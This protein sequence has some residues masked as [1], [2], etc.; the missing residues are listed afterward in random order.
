M[1]ARMVEV[2]AQCGV[3]AHS[4]R[5]YHGIRGALDKLYPNGIGGGG[6][7]DVREALAELYPDTPA[8]EPTDPPPPTP[9]QPPVA[10]A[11]LEAAAALEA[12]AARRHA[13]NLLQG[14]RPP[15]PRDAAATAAAPLRRPLT[16][17]PQVP[18]DCAVCGELGLHGATGLCTECRGVAATC[19]VCYDA[20][21][22]YCICVD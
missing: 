8:Q 17:A 12:T 6:G 14:L 3:Q 16:A 10:A 19:A 11:S 21:R 4:D 22:D 13:D 15:L 18:R 1:T 5:I 7:A 20:T 2:A 9:A